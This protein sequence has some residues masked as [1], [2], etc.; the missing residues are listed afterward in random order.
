M[1]YTI[2]AAIVALFCAWDLVE[3]EGRYIA[4][5]VRMITHALRAIGLS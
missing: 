4:Q 5:G 2:A 3:N 1:R